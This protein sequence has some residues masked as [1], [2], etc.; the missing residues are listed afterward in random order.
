LR[1]GKRASAR[2]ASFD[3]EKWLTV[4]ES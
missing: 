3:F 4:Y 2:Q 1:N